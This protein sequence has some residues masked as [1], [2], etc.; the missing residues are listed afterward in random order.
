MDG[1]K[2]CLAIHHGKVL[3]LTFCLLFFCIVQT[4]IKLDCRYITVCHQSVDI[5]ATMVA[6][7]LVG[8]K[9][10]D[11]NAETAGLLRGQ[12]LLSGSSFRTIRWDS[13]YTIIGESSIKIICL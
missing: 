11:G 8:I 4:R 6:N 5:T 7:I 2:S 13:I 1:A 10:C 9:C 3:K 12:N